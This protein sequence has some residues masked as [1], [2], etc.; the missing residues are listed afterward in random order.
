MSDTSIR[1]EWL[2]ALSDV[3]AKVGVPAVL[4]FVLLWQI[5]PK[6]D[7]IATKLERI[8]VMIELREVRK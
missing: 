5:C 7:M 6:L 8:V 3:V 2:T 1:R 4:A